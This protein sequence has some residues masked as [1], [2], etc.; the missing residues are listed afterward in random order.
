VETHPHLE[1][2]SLLGAR[3]VELKGRAFRESPAGE[4]GL[5]VGES[6]NGALQG[7]Q[8]GVSRAVLNHEDETKEGCG[9]V[10]VEGKRE[11]WAGER[12]KD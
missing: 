11:N 5:K 8:N 9:E 7:G 1:Q 4:E 10:R 6:G 2:H 12:S 3:E